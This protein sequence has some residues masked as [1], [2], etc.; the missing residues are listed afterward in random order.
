MIEGLAM[1]FSYLN[2]LVFL[3]YLSALLALFV[4]RSLEV[5]KLREDGLV[6]L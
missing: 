6:L 2:R 3:A 4:Y 5:V 1:L